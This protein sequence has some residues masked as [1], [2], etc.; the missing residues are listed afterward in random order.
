MKLFIQSLILEFP[1]QWVAGAGYTLADSIYT[2]T[3]ARLSLLGLLQYELSSRPRLAAWWQAV[4]LRPATAEARLVTS[5]GVAEL[6]KRLCT[7]L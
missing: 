7:I 3:L 6:A 2:C 4:Q 5:M 1:L